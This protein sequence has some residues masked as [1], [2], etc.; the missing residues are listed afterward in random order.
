MIITRRQIKDGKTHLTPFSNN[1]KPQNFVLLAPFIR[2]SLVLYS[3]LKCQS[4]QITAVKMCPYSQR[5][6]WYLVS[7]VND[8]L[9]L[10][11][12]PTCLTVFTS[13]VTLIL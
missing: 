10:N 13:K 1:D 4:I 11:F 5:D 2:V 6:Q 7:L 12:R 8:V 3:A 9:N